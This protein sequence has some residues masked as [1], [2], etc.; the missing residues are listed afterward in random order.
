MKKII[1]NLL[2]AGLFMNF[3]YPEL[4][5]QVNKF[6]FNGSLVN[7]LNQI[8]INELI[9]NSEKYLDDL[10]NLN[11]GLIEK[12]SEEHK[13]SSSKNNLPK[14][15]ILSTVSLK[16]IPGARGKILSESK[17]YLGIPYSFGSKDPST[18]F[19]CSGYVSYVYEKAINYTLPA[20]SKFQFA[21]GG[22]LLV[23]Y[24]QLKPG[25]L[26]FFSHNGNSIQH[27]GIFVGDEKFIHAPRTGRR[28]SIDEIGGY[29][30]QK[31]VKGK[32]YIQS[33]STK[34][35]NYQNEKQINSSTTNDSGLADIEAHKNTFFVNAEN[36]LNL[37]SSPSSNSVILLKL[38]NNDE[39]K[40]TAETDIM[41]TVKDYDSSGNF[42]GN[43]T[44]NWVKVKI[45]KNQEISEGYVFKGYLSSTK[46]EVKKE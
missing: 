10:G 36:G 6:R 7:Q 29:W 25:D 8:D 40:I 46:M 14:D 1:F 39:V 20:G 33:N 32:S 43:I 42:L 9:V 31:F 15:E 24:E 26:M 4:Q 16:N 18:G 38:N 5:F 12:K 27:V 30:K 23:N 11:Q 44:D 37:R 22:G 13:I 17:K 41:L 28:I 35:I 34:I 2:I 45:T 3:V 21:N 19:D